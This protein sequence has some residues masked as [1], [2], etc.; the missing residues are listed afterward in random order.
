MP[1]SKLQPLLLAACAFAQSPESR[2]LALTHV[3]IVHTETGLS[4][5]DMTVLTTG[6]VVVRGGLQIYR[7]H[8][9]KLAETWVASLPDGADW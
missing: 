8:N 7:I 6:K 5:P 4:E 1:L 3:S 2:P 9:G